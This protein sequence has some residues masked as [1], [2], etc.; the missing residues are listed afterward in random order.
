MFE[1]HWDLE[2]T[3]GARSKFLIIASCLDVVTV[4]SKRS[5]SDDGV[6]LDKGTGWTFSHSVR[7][8]KLH[9]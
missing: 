2:E 1:T 8:L 7:K 6:V 4:N 5:D 3:P 9:Q